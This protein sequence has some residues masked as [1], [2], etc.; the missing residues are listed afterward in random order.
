[1]KLFNKTPKDERLVAEANRTYKIAYYV[2]TVGILVDIVWSGIEGQFNQREWIVFM[3][4]QIVAVLLNIYKG[5]PDPGTESTSGTFPLK[6]VL[7][8]SCLVGA[9]AGVFGCVMNFA[10]GYWSTSA[11]YIAQ[12][13]LIT[14]CGFLIVTAALTIV[15]QAIVFAATKARLNRMLANADKDE[16]DL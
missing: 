11:P 4:A 14:F 5:V 13:M 7:L 10:R 6:R 8:S 16:T 12:A 2:F 3:I 9:A 1:M 15:L